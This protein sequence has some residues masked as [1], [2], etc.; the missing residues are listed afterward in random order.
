MRS[1]PSQAGEAMSVADSSLI[2]DRWR[3][4]NAPHLVVVSAQERVV[5]GQLIEQPDETPQPKLAQRSSSTGLDDCSSGLRPT[6]QTQNR[7][8]TGHC[9]NADRNVV[10]P[11]GEARWTITRIRHCRCES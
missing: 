3:A 9:P 1:A 10:N 6:N 5:N 4:V 7:A 2:A 8:L 11:G